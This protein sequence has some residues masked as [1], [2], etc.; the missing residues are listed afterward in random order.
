MITKGGAPSFPYQ[1]LGVQECVCAGQ[2]SRIFLVYM[3]YQMTLTFHPSISHKLR[4]GLN[5]NKEQF[6]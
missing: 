4:D 6:S 3:I 1:C 2:V 5:Y